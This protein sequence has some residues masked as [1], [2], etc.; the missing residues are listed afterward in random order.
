MD[1]FQKFVDEFLDFDENWGHF[2]GVILR[3]FI[4]TWAIAVPI[5]WSIKHL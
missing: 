3:I 2:F 1:K 5:V 4:I